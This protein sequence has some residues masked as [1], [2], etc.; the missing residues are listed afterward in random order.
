[1]KWLNLNIAVFL[2]LKIL[3]SQ[4]KELLQQE[5]KKIPKNR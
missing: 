5:E 1:M 4:I 2:V 3:F